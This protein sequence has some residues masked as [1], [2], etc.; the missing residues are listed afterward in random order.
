[1][2]VGSA[3]VAL[4]SDDM[5]VGMTETAILA[6]VGT[7]GPD[8]EVSWIFNGKPVV[9]TSLITIHE[10]V[11]VVGETL[12]KQSLLQICGL[13]ESDA[14]D[15]TCVISDGNTNANATTKLSVKGLL[16]G[17]IILTNIRLPFY[18]MATK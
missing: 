10:E 1:M 16:V 7:G 9:N 15:Y 12:L 18:N 6:C 8:I 13:V 4:I 3:E 11:I 17:N 14:G 2:I 5:F